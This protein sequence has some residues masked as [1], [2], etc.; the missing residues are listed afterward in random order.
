MKKLL[1][2]LLLAIGLFIV[3]CEPVD[4]RED[5]EINSYGTFIV[6]NTTG[7]TVWVDIDNIDERKLYHGGQTTYNR[8]SSGNHKMYIDLGDGW[9]Y[10]NQYLSSCETLTYT[11]YLTGK[12][13]TEQLALDVYEG[14]VFL[15]TITE[16]ERDAER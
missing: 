5:C 8:V 3:S 2:I 9:Q 11:W 14:G 4:V 1:G 12:K 16:F 10:Q 7:F 13:S 6:Q 15:K